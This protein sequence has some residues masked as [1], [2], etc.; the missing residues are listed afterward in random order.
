MV[1]SFDGTPLDPAWLEA[2]CAEALG[3]PTAGNCAGVRMHVVA[4]DDLGAYFAAATDEEWRARSRR[5]PGLARAGAAVLVTSRVEAY[6]AR[7]REPDKAGAGLGR[8]DAWPVPYWH[9]DAA[10]ATMALLLLLE[11]ASWQ[12][13]LWGRFRHHDRV[14]AWAGLGD[15]EIFATVLIGRADGQDA[16][17]ASLG[18]TVPSRAERVRRVET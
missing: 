4:A 9:T 6:L 18:R 8:R 14:A 11:E 12:A 2:R 7:Y 15:E 17:S 13:T 3:A 10:M 5:Y 16:P 1:R